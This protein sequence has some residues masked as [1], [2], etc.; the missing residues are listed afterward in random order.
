MSWKQPIP[1]DVD[2]V[3][4]TDYLCAELYVFL[5]LKSANK[6][7]FFT[8]EKTKRTFE[9]KKGQVVFGS[10]R[11]AEIM[12][13]SPATI[14]RALQKLEKTYQKVNNSAH[15]GF[16]VVSIKN[17]EEITGL[18][19]SRI[20]GEQVVNTSKSIKTIKKD[21]TVGQTPAGESFLKVWNEVF[22]TAY[23]STTAIERPL[24]VWLQSY[25]LEQI[26]QAVR[27]I[28]NDSYWKDK[29]VDPIW[30][31]RFRDSSGDIDRIGKMLNTKEKDEWR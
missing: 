23:S 11:W 12:R 30:L 18:N 21:I 7:G 4:G 25:S 28:K 1:T 6:D 5:L 10:N 16:T 14:Y 3:F 27:N 29:D 19:N 24:A 15:Q 17:Y 8:D 26:C 22:S 9:I 13:T 31:L 20:T 2:E